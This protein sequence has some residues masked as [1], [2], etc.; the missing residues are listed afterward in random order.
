MSD[1]SVVAV[2]DMNGG[3]GLVLSRPLRF[4][5]SRSGKDFIGSDGPFRDVLR[6]D[7]ASDAFA[8]RELSL[9][10]DDGST[11]TVK[12]HWWQSYFPGC[13]S[14]AFGDVESLRKCYVFSG[15]ACI[16][17]FDLAALRAT[18]TG[19]V[20][21]Y[22][23]YERVVKH[24]EM[25]RELW[26]RVRREERRVASAVAEAKRQAAR[27][28][29]AERALANV[30]PLAGWEQVCRAV[31]GVIRE[32]REW[33]QH[34]ESD[35]GAQTLANADFTVRAWEQTLAGAMY[36]DAGIAEEPSRG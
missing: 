18:Y 5:Y 29:A 2:V 6:Y 33:L 8:G 35:D 34:A 15:G 11:E 28:D 24:D 36:A 16:S 26:E 27:A 23:D 19:C 20:Y 3:E 32:M 1:L 9:L 13:V 31:P 21:P 22:W 12:D 10:M 30:A 4:V 17:P 25:R 14:V 7:R